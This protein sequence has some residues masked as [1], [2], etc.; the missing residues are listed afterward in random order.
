[1]VLAG[2]TRALFRREG[3]AGPGI[4]R[5]AVGIA[6]PRFARGDKPG[7]LGAALERRIDK[8]FCFEPFERGAVF[9]EVRGLAAYGRFPF[10]AEPGEIL[11]DRRL[12]LRP[13]A[14]A[15]D[16]LDAQ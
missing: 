15:V 6:R 7:D 11:V 10:D 8:A 12:E 1:M 4:K 9:G 3:A 2:A 16:V 13:A 5:R 14:A